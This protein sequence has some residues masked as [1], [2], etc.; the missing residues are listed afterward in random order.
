MKINLMPI[1]IVRL[2]AV[3][4]LVLAMLSFAY[5]LVLSSSADF[6]TNT[7]GTQAQVWAIFGLN[8]IFGIGFASSSYGLWTHQNWGRVVFLWTIGLWAGFNLLGLLGAGLWWG[9]ERN[10]TLVSMAVSG[11]RYAATLALPLWYLN[12]PRIKARFSD[13][14]LDD[15]FFE[16]DNG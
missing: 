1:L 13:G 14:K 10:D 5:L 7:Y 6:V 3:W 2:V 12:L 4:A 15:T 11:L 16:S 8:L 9:V